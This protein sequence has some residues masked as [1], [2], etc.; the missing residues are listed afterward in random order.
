MARLSEPDQREMQTVKRLC[1]QGLDS[2]TLRET[3]GER[4]RRHLAADAFPARARTFLETLA[5]HPAAGLRA[6]VGRA[7]LG[8]SPGAGV[9]MV[10]LG[11]GGGIELAN[12]VALRLLQ[13]TAVGERRSR[14]VAIQTVAGLLGRVLD[15][16]ASLV[17]ALDVVDDEVGV[18]SRRALA[19]VL[20]G[21]RDNRA[22]PGEPPPL[23][24][25]SQ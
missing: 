3:V 25:A 7:T 8:A 1:Y 13:G 2:A 5:P 23:P 19:A 16:E 10:L 4:L 20:G 14:W 18:D 11:P 9:G 24:R 15:G 6:A 22:G 17:P 12:D 21:L